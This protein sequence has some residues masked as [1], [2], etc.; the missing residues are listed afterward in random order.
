MAKITGQ[1]AKVVLDDT[2]VDGAFSWEMSGIEA[3]EIETTEF[4]DNFKTYLYGA[5]DGGSITV[6][7]YVDPESVPQEALEALLVQGTEFKNLKL[8]FD[9]DE[10]FYLTPNQWPGYLNPSNA[11][12]MDT[13]DTT[14]IVTG[15]TISAEASGMIEVSWTMRINGVMV[16]VD[17][18]NPPATSP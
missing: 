6:N 4:C 5:K 7:G 11:Q 8:Y 13:P 9:R 17:S 16:K 12:N 2:K 15:Q 3:E 14:L 10:R 18:Q 1:C